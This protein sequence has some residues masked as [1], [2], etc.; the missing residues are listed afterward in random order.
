[1]T[2]EVVGAANRLAQNILDVTEKTLSDSDQKFTSST[3]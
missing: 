3:K 1:M 2:E